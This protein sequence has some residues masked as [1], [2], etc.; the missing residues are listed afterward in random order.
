MTMT[1]NPLI[2]RCTSLKTYIQ[3]N[4]LASIASNAPI[5]CF[6]SKPT[7]KNVPSVKSFVS[8]FHHDVL[9]RY[10][11]KPQRSI[12]S[13]SISSFFPTRKDVQD[14]QDL[15]DRTGATTILG[16][17]SGAAMDLVKALD[18]D[19]KILIPGTSTAVFAAGTPFALILDVETELLW[20]KVITSDGEQQE[21]QFFTSQHKNNLTTIVQPDLVATSPYAMPACDAILLDA[22]YR[23]PERM[24]DLQSASKAMRLDSIIEGPLAASGHL[25]AGQ[26]Y[27]LIP[28]GNESHNQVTRSALLTMSNSLLPSFFPRMPLFAFWASL[29]PGLAQTLFQ[30]KIPQQP[31]LPNLAEGYSVS[32]PDSKL[33][34]RMLH[35]IQLHQHIMSPVNNRGG[36]GVSD[37]EMEQ[38]EQVLKHSLGFD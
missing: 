30:R 15:V 4:V 36:D 1:T 20:T 26:S 25:E 31:S 5:V 29:L 34:E 19:H 2:I 17:G 33:V 12:I 23:T 27:A 18:V 32:V 10:N 3:N 6:D 35:K 37:M 21:H 7:R 11:Q 9:S 14:A 28:S 16:I 13:A 38:L 8:N 22:T 24:L